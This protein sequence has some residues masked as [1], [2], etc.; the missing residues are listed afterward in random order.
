MED[1]IK[2]GDIVIKKS[3]GTRMTVRS[4]DGDVITCN[5]FE[6]SKLFQEEFSLQKHLMV[7]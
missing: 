3:N 2:V 6:D 5:W 7:C 1:I 4:I